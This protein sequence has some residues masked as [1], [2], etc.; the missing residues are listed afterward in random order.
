MTNN[1]VSGVVNKS[2]AAGHI[3]RESGRESGSR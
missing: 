1:S 3:K 2:R